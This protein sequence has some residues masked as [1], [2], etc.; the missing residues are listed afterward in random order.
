D[1]AEADRAEAARE[2]EKALAEGPAREPPAPTPRSLAVIDAALAEARTGEGAS[3]AALSRSQSSL[4]E[5]EDL[6]REGVCPRCHQAV[7]AP[8]FESHR[9]E[10]TTATRTLELAHRAAVTERENL[11]LERRARER[12]ERAHERWTEAERRRAF[13]ET[14]LARAAAATESAREALRGAD[15]SAAEVL[16]RVESLAPAEAEEE[17][18]RQELTESE[19]E[20]QR[21]TRELEKAV[22]AS[23]RRDAARSGAEAIAHELERL[24]RDLGSILERSSS[25][26][27][28]QQVLERML[29]GAT[30]TAR[31]R[32]EAET[33]L[34]G[35]RRSLEETKV[36]RARTEARWE[37]A[38]RRIRAAETGRTERAGLLSE[39]DDLER[40][41]AW[42]A[43]PFRTTLLTMEQKLLGHAQAVFER[44]FARYFASLVDDP[45]LV[46]RT[47]VA[48]TPA[49]TIEG[50]WTPAEAL[51]G[52][53]RTSLALA[54]RIAL[55]QV[56]RTLGSLRLDTILLDEPT[57]GFS[58]EQVVRMGELLDELA[59]PQVVIVS[60][61]A[62][63][64]SIADRVV[65]V[66]KRGGRSTLSVP[67][68]EGVATEVRPTFPQDRPIG[69]KATPRGRSATL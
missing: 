52:G 28:R 67:S 20:L 51:S 34:A 11:E 44:H 29:E 65:R 54:F 10:A 7:R 42:V 58:P 3:L 40:K 33:E 64:A 41:A 24:G 14:A 61:E 6:L 1:R 43:G 23:S 13:A 15:A 17:R 60:H 48:F 18:L 30:E 8:E 31:A 37:D 12:Y 16:R 5:L 50:E 2:K 25:R 27:A 26:S 32:A 66:E 55:A 4:A 57:D 35:R 62:E 49:V 46:A 56:V 47:D 63:L 22:E 38:V 19:S 45:G 9:S 53:E 59:L 21:R 39:A 69:G 36:V 68:V